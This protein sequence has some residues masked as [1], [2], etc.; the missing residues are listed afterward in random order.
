MNCTCQNSGDLPAQKKNN[1]RVALID[2]GAKQNI[3]RRA[4][5]ARLRVTV[6]PATPAEEILAA[7]PDGVMLSN[8]PGNPADNPSAS[9]RFAPCWASSP[10]SASVLGHQL[11][12]LAAGEAFTGE[13]EVRPSR[14]NPAVRRRR[15][16]HLH[17]QPE[18]RLRR[19]VRLGEGRTFCASSRQRPHLRGVDYP[20]WN[21]FTVQFHPEACSGPKDTSFLFDRFM[22]MMGGES[23]C[24]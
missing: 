22:S 1:A 18:P 16:P 2:Y 24:R 17:H 12:A 7:H 10:C 5:E 21:A 14:R 8:G 13:D 4:A 19:R 15:K 11:M 6:F 3:I 9:R 23:S 20:E